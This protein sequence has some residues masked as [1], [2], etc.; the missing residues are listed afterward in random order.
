MLSEKYNVGFVQLNTGFYEQH[1]LP[2]AAGMLVSFA[3][4]NIN[5]S[6]KFL[7]DV[8][9][10]FFGDVAKIAEELAH[11]DLVAFSVYVWNEQNSLEIA[12][13]LKKIKPNVVIVFGGPQVP[14]SQKQFRR[15]RT[16]ELTAAEKKM[17]RAFFTEDYH[18]LYPYIDFICHGEGERV[19]V[20]LLEE[21]GPNGGRDLSSIPS[22]SYVKNG[23]FYFND[24][25][26][27]QNS[28]Q[29]SECPSP[30]LNGYFDKLLNK[31]P[32]QKWILMYETDRG[33]PYQCSYCD[34]GG[35]TEDKLSKFNLERIEQ[36][37]DWIGSSK[38]PYVFLA[39]ANFGIIPRDV[40]I[41]NFFAKT[42]KKYGYPE[43]VS[44]QNAKNPKPHTIAALEV[45][46]RA[47]LN[48][49]TVMSHQSLNE[50][51]LK[52]VRRDN[53]KLDEYQ[54]M[55]NDLSKNGIYT[56]TD[57][58]F[59]MPGETYDTFTNA[60][61]TLVKNGQYNRIQFN[62]LSIL[63]NTEMGNPE[64]QKTH[65]FEL[66]KTKIINIHGAKRRKQDGV[67]E[68]QVLVIASETMPRKD[69]LKSRI[70]S[71]VTNFLF[72][73]KLLQIP[74]A[75]LQ[76]QFEFSTRT[77]VEKFIGLDKKKYSIIPL[78]IG[79]FE[80]S[81]QDLQNG[82]GDEFIH[83]EEY[84]DI[85][86]PA[87]ELAHINLVLNTNMADFYSEARNIFYE[88]IESVSSKFQKKALDES[89]AL[90]HFLLKTPNR[91]FSN[92]LELETNIGL[93]YQGILRGQ[94]VTL[95]SESCEVV[96][97]VESW[98]SIQD[99]CEK[100]V[101]FGNRQGAYIHG[102]EIQKKKITFA[103]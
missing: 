9:I 13:E 37:I 56:M 19:F 61:S 83:S 67:E 48:K 93:I 10:C 31:Y 65:G 103:A 78:I 49:A 92:A 75:L 11:C 77:I 39:N 73:N 12:K 82:L 84:L 94:E 60:V 5:N 87:D 50:E 46:K 21:L 41:A 3:Q 85:Y 20:R 34:W 68:Y 63:I 79:F 42:K 4:K 2:L 55:Q 54:K 43:G 52:L 16:K 88:L 51:T 45:L 100:V 35:A 38:I 27:R 90:N 74:I 91:K 28:E 99:W 23:R 1:Y 86:W 81:A 101:W 57:L 47:G 62:N 7:F 18:L 6:D 102:F 72:F 25:L 58:I 97:S 30:L 69:W 15:L 44:T 36:E 98:P 53:M 89:I 71:W 8:P 76:N 70:F 14:N 32:D 66:V 17:A 64:Y 22:I 33:C 24:L 95:N 80:Q 26:P 96:I 40:E 29:L 59:P